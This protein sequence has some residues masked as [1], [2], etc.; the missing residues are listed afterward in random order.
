MLQLLSLTKWF[1]IQTTIIHDKISS[2]GRVLAN[3]WSHP[4]S[5]TKCVHLFIRSVIQKVTIATIYVRLSVVRRAFQPKP[6]IILG[7]GWYDGHDGNNKKKMLPISCPRIWGCPDNLIS[8]EN[9]PSK[10]HGGHISNHIIFPSCLKL[11]TRE[12]SVVMLNPGMWR[13]PFAANHIAPI[14]LTFFTVV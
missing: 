2:Q 13:A 10:M 12:V 11:S 6:K 5:M 7:N 3:G 14:P 1:A 9:S 8:G 4:S